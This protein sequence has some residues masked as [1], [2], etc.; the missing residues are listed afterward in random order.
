MLPPEGLSSPQ[1]EAITPTAA[2]RNSGGLA[3]A[4]ATTAAAAAAP[5]IEAAALE[6]AINE[7]FNV[8][9]ASVLARATARLREIKA[10]DAQ[11]LRAAC[12]ARVDEAS[13]KRLVDARGG[14]ASP[15]KVKCAALTALATARAPF[16]RW[17]LRLCMC[18]ICCAE[19]ATQTLR[20][21]LR[22]SVHCL[23]LN[24]ASASIRV[25]PLH[26][27]PLSVLSAAAAPLTH[28]WAVCIVWRCASSQTSI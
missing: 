27:A 10:A 1:S 7:R 15:S 9:S 26:A 16:V 3:A 23:K 24:T 11:I 13:L 25:P 5:A 8:A 18:L 20:L 28:R 21:A 22:A 19:H 4:T 14:D 12:A 6:L 17:C 2:N